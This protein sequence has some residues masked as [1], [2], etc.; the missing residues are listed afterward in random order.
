MEYERL[1]RLLVERGLPVT[2]AAVHG[3]LVGRLAGGE[4]LSGDALERALVA[5]LESEPARA[6]PLLEDLADCYRAER[7]AL[8]SG[9][10][11]FR[12]LLPG[13]DVPLGRRV[14]ELAAW[15]RSFLS[16]F[17]AVVAGGEQLSADARELLADLGQIAQ[18]GFGGEA[19]EAD[20]RDFVEVAEYVRIAALNLHA[21]CAPA[22]E[23]EAAGEARE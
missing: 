21:E 16:G 13:D 7:S 17:G 8:A 19:V 10:L 1:A 11:S 5:A 22:R 14:E 15:C 4:R 3:H 18:A 12:P 20:E 9:E 6:E 2:A 23:G